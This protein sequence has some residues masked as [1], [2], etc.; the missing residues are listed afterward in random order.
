[1]ENIKKTPSSVE[2]MI[3]LAVTIVN[4]QMK[5]KIFRLAPNI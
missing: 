1:M 5:M 3:D 2:P 4:T